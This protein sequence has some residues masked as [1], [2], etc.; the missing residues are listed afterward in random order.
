MTEDKHPNEKRFT[1][2][3]VGDKQVL[4][5]EMKVLC[6]KLGVHVNDKLIELVE[7]FIKKSNKL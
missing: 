2:H 1:I 5:W 6:A 3:Y 7:E 4:R